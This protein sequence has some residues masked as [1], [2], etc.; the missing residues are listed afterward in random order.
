MKIL[1]LLLLIPM[2]ALAS[3]LVQPKPRAAISVG[4]GWSAPRCP[5]WPHIHV[6]TNGAVVTTVF[7]DPLQRMTN[8]VTRKK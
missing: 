8:S 7:H 3:S 1:L 2:I 4:W 6:S 5:S